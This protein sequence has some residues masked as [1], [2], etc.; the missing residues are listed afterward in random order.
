MSPKYMTGTHS[1]T[2][3]RSLRFMEIII[4]DMEQNTI[5]G[6]KLTRTVCGIYTMCRRGL[7]YIFWLKMT[8][9][10]SGL[11]VIFMCNLINKTGESY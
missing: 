2:F 6:M 10:F 1:T 8:A 11:A 4:F 7:P 5:S 3:A 9:D